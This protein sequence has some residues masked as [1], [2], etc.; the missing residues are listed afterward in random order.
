MRNP[1]SNIPQGKSTKSKTSLKR[2]NP[3]IFDQCET[4]DV[5]IFRLDQ[6]WFLYYSIYKMIIKVD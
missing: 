1:M 2:K 6:Q 4:D 5:S 3:N